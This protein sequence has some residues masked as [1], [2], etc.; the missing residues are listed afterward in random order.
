MSYTEYVQLQG[1]T[2][3]ET[4]SDI[5]GNM[6]MFLGMSVIT[7]VEVIMFFTKIVW[8]TISKKRRDYMYKKKMFEKVKMRY[9]DEFFVI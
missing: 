3:T 2:I 5:G 7:L 8:I 6:G 1:T 4:L 9:N